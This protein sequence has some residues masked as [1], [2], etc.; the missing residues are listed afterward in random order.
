MAR[1]VLYTVADRMPSYSHNA[2]KTD[3][4]GGYYPRGEYLIRHATTTTYHAD[5]VRRWE[6]DEQ[7]T[8][9]V[10]TYAGG[11]EMLVIMPARDVRKYLER[12]DY[13]PRCDM[14]ADTCGCRNPNRD[15][16]QAIAAFHGLQ[17][18][19]SLEV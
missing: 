3:D 19:N 2:P 17:I 18:V 15:H 11:E 1:A 8:A 12:G 6:K 10:F 9:A 5:H 14:M 4:N 7:T 13:C 16:L